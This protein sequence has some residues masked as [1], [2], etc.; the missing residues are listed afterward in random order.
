M[1]LVLEFVY[2]LYDLCVAYDSYVTHVDSYANYGFGVCT[3]LCRT[4]HT[5]FWSFEYQFHLIARMGQIREQWGRHKSENEALTPPVETRPGSAPISGAAVAT[6][7]LQ[8]KDRGECR[9][10]GDPLHL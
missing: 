8:Q 5:I 4:L 7:G 6:G 1:C 2:D 9:D 10:P 3:Q